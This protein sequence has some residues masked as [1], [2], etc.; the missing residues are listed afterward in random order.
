MTSDYSSTTYKLNRWVHNLLV[1]CSI[2]RVLECTD[3]GL[4]QYFN[5]WSAH[6]LIGA[7]FL[8]TEN[9]K[10][11]RLLTTLYSIYIA[12]RTEHSHTHLVF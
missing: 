12:F 6:Y 2:D 10:H 1:M 3:N 7:Y 11:M 4:G 8:N 9:D 5:L